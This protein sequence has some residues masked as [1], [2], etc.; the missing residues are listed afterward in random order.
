MSRRLNR[1]I[2]KCPNIKSAVRA[3][4]R[5]IENKTLEKYLARLMA[6]M[7]GE[8]NPYKRN[9]GYPFIWH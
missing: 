2:E 8:I 3:E 6:R 9:D 1:Y 5:R 4:N 7:Y